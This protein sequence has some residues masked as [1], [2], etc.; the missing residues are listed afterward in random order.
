[1]LLLIL[2]LLLSL[3]NGNDIN[4]QF[5]IEGRIHQ[6]EYATKTTAKGSSII[7]A[8][9]KDTAIL[10]SYRGDIKSNALL[11]QSSNLSM[12]MISN[13]IGYG[14][15]G[16]SSDIN[17]LSNK[18][19]DIVLNHETIFDSFVP[20]I[21]ITDNLA[22]YIHSR[23]I[24]SK[25]RPF[26]IRLCIIGYD[27]SNGASVIDI[28]ALGNKHQNKL[29]CLG[30]RAESLN[31]LWDRKIDPLF[32]SSSEL[33]ERLIQILKTC[34]MNE[35]LQLNKDDISIALV[36]KDKPFTILNNDQIEEILEKKNFDVNLM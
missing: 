23:T 13:N 11:K 8:H 9:N 25:Y 16:I 7:A 32:L 27:K 34:L 10:I 33:I 5:T 35:K 21:R 29:C 20:I 22:S 24:T 18:L 1:M 36:G 28:D 4:S 15:T 2:F 26:G 30:P 31:N 17:Y 6:I 12:K 3:I 19:F 14:A